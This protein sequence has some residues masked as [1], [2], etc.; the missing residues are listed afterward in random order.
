MK[1][2]KRPV[3][4]EA[5]CWDGTAEGATPII[6]W[7]L[8]GGGTARFVD[9]EDPD[10]NPAYLAIDTLEGTMRADPGDW[11]ICG[12]AGE[13]YPCKPDIFEQSYTLDVDPGPTDGSAYVPGTRTELR[14]DLAAV[15]N[16]HSAEND[17]NTPDFI[18]AG[19]LVDCLDAYA[20]AVVARG[21][22]F[23]DPR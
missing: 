14:R 19:F 2:R 18:L 7:V 9:Y 15:I 12:V 5:M 11:V 8:D 4:I 6:D 20:G 13:F 17:S 10:M 16:R 3:V 23:G 22:W 1:Y 21:S